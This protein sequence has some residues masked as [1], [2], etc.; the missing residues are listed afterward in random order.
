MTPPSSNNAS[1][2]SITLHCQWPHHPLTMPVFLQSLYT[3]SDPTVLY[4][5]QCFFHHSPSHN[6]V[7]VSSII[8][9]P[10]TMSVFLPS[11][12]FPNN[13]SVS[14]ITLHFQWPH[15]PL[16]MSVFLPSLTIPSQCQCFF[17]HSPSSNN[18]SVSSITHHPLTMSVFLPSLTIS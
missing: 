11:P 18:F 13:T 1:V 9:L 2:S 17:H 7:N 15:H 12:H 6:Y 14:S 5:C 8:P 10:L 4:K 16:K 3:V